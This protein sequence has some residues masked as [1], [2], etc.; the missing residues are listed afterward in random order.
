MNHKSIF[1]ILALAGVSHSYGQSVERS[2][3]ASGGAVVSAGNVI[4][5]YTV[6]ETVVQTA[7]AGSVILT[8][9][10]QQPEGA[11]SG[12]EPIAASAELT[13]FPNPSDG[14]FTIQSLN[15]GLQA[16]T[17]LYAE[18]YDGTGKLV[19]KQSLSFDGG[20]GALNVSA[21]PGGLYTLRLSSNTGVTSAFRLTIVK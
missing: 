18:V 10:F 11:V 14:V 16:Q 8:Q 13:V 15:D 21:L 5:S 12:V 1:A 7:A 20:V 9:G 19:D 6:G 4:L 17:E 3:I 2:V